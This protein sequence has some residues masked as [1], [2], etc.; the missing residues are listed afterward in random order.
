MPS[1]NLVSASPFDRPSIAVSLASAL[2]HK[3]SHPQLRVID[4]VPFP[5]TNTAVP[6]LYS[7]R[8]P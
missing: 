4:N 2:K 6:R 1:S 7:R 5:L 3:P 8:E